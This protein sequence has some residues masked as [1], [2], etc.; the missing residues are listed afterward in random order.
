MYFFTPDTIVQ[1]NKNIEALDPKVGG[2]LCILSCLADNIEE[3]VNYTVNGEQL[4][5]Q[6]SFVFD[7]EPK[8]SFDGAKPSYIIFAKE[9]VSTFFNNYIRGKVDLLSCAVFFLRRYKFDREFTKDEVID[10]FIKRFNL[11]NYKNKWFFD[12]N[13]VS[14]AYNQGNVEDNQ[15]EYYIK[16]GYTSAFKSILFRNVIQ[17]SASDLK[18]AGQIQTLY[19]GSGIHTCLLLSDEPLDQYYIMKNSSQD[20]A[21]DSMIANNEQLFKKWFAR[22]EKENGEPYSDNTRNQYIGALKAVPSAFSDAIAPLASVF[23][24]NDQNV[25]DRVANAIKDAP[26]FDEFNKARGNG[27]LSAALDM[28]GRFLSER[29]ENMD[30]MFTPEWFRE[31]SAEYPNLD[32]E[33]KQLLA[34]FQSKFSPDHLAS[35]SGVDMLNTIFLNAVNADNVCRVLEFGPQ[36]KDTFGSIKGGNAYKYGLYYSTQGNWMTGSHQ[37]P[38][39]L[40]EEE[41]IE[42]GV[43]LRDHL[44]A[45]AKAIKNHGPLST[46]EDYKKLHKIL[47]EVTEGDIERVWFLKYYQMLYPELFATNYSDYAQRTVLNAIGEEKEKYALVRMGQIRFYAN[48]C[49]IS[50][51]M[52]NKIFW[53]YY[54]EEAV[55]A[56]KNEPSQDVCF[57]TGY[58]SDYARNRILFGAPGTGKSYTLN[59]EKDTLLAD[60]GEYERVTFH[61]DYSYANFVGTYKPVPCTDNNG[62]DAITYAYVPGP[63]MR[64]YVKALLNSRTD[65]PKPFLLVIEE[66]NRANVAAVFGDVFQLLD[67]GDD[68]V[69]EYAIQASEDI[70]KY[71]AEKLGGDPEEYAEIRI[72]DNMFIWATMN[73]ADQGVFPMDTAFKRRWDFTYLGIDDS[74]DGIK[75]KT[76]ILGKGDHR[77]VV[78]WNELRKAINEELL[79]YK[80][81][82][83]KLM[84]PY[85]ISKKM[86]PEGDTID[87]TIFTRV[88]KN[89]VIMYLFDDAAK[90]KRIT[91][92]GGCAEKDKNQ[93]SKI[94]AA[95]DTLG[96][97]IFCD[98]ISSRFI[99]KA[100]EGDAE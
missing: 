27:S 68:E 14:L 12:G 16:M 97:D 58:H 34:D 10:L 21:E 96:V 47:T 79:T 59:K 36:I 4:R 41:A 86:L 93:Y 46:I 43:K 40:T 55:T 3:N 22:Q 99:D 72:P 63:F 94:C 38:R 51:V 32:A 82:E 24:V 50:N 87:P 56:Q 26:N 28:Y 65:A 23:Q 57:S 90:Q 71:L 64:T 92:F 83:D 45:G 1:A 2:L 54:S 44:V 25:F 62:N 85:F 66:I 15:S 6:L 70:K 13:K 91:L 89:K 11:A 84:G 76:V 33:A 7:K 20:N 29:D 74:E 53:E 9:W 30:D 52:F 80:V 61:P 100:P 95:F 73:S 88:F 31:K 19:S 48:K 5:R 42:V 49:G 78:E 8:D 77:K 18:A 98:S 39:Q 37:K 35:L 67:R 69:S 17:K 81:N 60:G 75:G